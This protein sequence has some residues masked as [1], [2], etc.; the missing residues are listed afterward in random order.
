VDYKD[1]LDTFEAELTLQDALKLSKQYHIAAGELL[2][3]AY[4][5]KVAYTF[6]DSIASPEKSSGE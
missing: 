1:E 6:K 5:G 3:R 2:A 4:E